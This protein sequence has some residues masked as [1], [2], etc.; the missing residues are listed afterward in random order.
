MQFDGI[1]KLE[2]SEARE[3]IMTPEGKLSFMPEVES[4]FDNIGSGILFVINSNKGK[5]IMRPKINVL[6]MRKCID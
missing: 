6:L 5:E 4:M 1:S 2:N 3:E